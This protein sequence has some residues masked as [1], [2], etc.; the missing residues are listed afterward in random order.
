MSTTHIAALRR[1]LLSAA[2]AGAACGAHAQSSVPDASWHAG[3]SYGAIAV[4]RSHFGTSCGTVAGLTCRNAGTAVSLTAGD[5]F[6]EHLGAELSYLNFGHADR[7]GGS[8]RAQAL[9]LALVGRLPV[10]DR[11]EVKGKVGA[12]YGITHTSAAIDA[13]LSTGRATG[14]GLGYGVGLDYHINRRLDASVEWQRHDLHFAGQGTS[15]V[16]MVTAGVGF[17]F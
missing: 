11:L 6:T 16:S 15:P 8:V 13:G 2:L 10:T 12:T 4:G 3:S 9:D 14:W 7:A 5:M 17:R 1:G